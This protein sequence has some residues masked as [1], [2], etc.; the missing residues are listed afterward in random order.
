M[1]DEKLMVPERSN[2]SRL[3]SLSALLCGV[4]VPLGI[5]LV[6]LDPVPHNLV[7]LLACVGLTCA[8][9]AFARGN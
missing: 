8:G 5:V 3:G 9:A 6:V 4:T 1:N 2:L 7:A